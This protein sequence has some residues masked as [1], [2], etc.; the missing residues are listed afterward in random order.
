[1]HR[2][3]WLIL[4]CLIIVI[5]DTSHIKVVQQ[6]WKSIDSFLTCLY[7]RSGSHTCSW[8]QSEGG[9]GGATQ[10]PTVPAAVDW[11]EI[12]GWC[13]C[14]SQ[15][16]E[17]FRRRDHSHWWELFQAI[18]SSVMSFRDALWRWP[19]LDNEYTTF[20]RFGICKIKNTLFCSPRLH[21]LDKN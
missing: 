10:H 3:L 17:E 4:F 1:M 12:S 18:T 11:W 5:L 13:H 16:D 19:L 20:Q 6:W 21:L 7:F 2:F 8:E 9:G 14:C 15:Q